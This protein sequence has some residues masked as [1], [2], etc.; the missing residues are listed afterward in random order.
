M[1]LIDD[2]SSQIPRFSLFKEL[3][4]KPEPLLELSRTMKHVVF[5]VREFL[6][7]EKQNDDRMF[8]LL[9]GQVEV[10]KIDE[11]GQII[12]IGKADAH[13]HPYFGESV[14]FGNFKRSANVVA[15]TVCECLSLSAK[16]FEVFT[17]RYPHVVATFYR[18]LAHVLFERLAKTDRDVFIAGLSLKRQR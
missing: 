8:F 7:D 12:A 13:T 3:E 15:I 5:N 18:Q 6:I 1:S 4:G 10:N 17:D 2:F 16:D 11:N 14:L 9:K